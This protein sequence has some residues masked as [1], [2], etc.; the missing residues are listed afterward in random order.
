[1]IPGL[2]EHP[3]LLLSSSPSSTGLRGQRP[4]CKYMCRQCNT[5]VPRYEL[6]LWKMP[7]GRHL[8]MHRAMNSIKF[9]PSPR[10]QRQQ[11]SSSIKAVALQPI[12][13]PPH[14]QKS[15]TSMSYLC[16]QAPTA[17]SSNSRSAA[18]EMRAALSDLSSHASRAPCFVC[19]R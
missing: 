19:A 10:M 1:M 7:S 16:C 15:T 4:T 2:V 3:G 14:H 6:L 11:H 17:A 8:G 13:R 18:L 12:C 9:S 5:Y